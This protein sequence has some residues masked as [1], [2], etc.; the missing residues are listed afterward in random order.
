LGRP[1]KPLI[2]RESAVAAA[3]AV[4]DG[5]GL[6]AFSLGAV[7]RRLGVK[8][9]SL[10]YHFHDK[11]EL[12][13]QVARQLLLEVP[14]ARDVAGTWD[15]RTIALCVAARRSLLKH[16]NAAPLLL[17]FFPL[18]LLLG[19]YEQAIIINPARPELKMVI[20][21]GL[22]H[23]TFG[24]TLFAASARARSVSQMPHVD[25]ER[26]PH[27]A[28]SIAANPFDEEAAF[29]QTLRIF[30]AGVKVLTDDRTGTASVQAG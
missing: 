13:A 30:L 27:L 4:I 19:G 24:S 5:E 2:S 10:Y 21:E 7:A 26:Y 6:A 17:Q 25:P 18:H 1:G 28:G 23:L 16:P 14:F 22:D 29:V 20:Q 15:E 9:P 11:A 12:L 8:S 3:I